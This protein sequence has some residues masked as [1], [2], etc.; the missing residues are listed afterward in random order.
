MTDLEI[1]TI[2]ITLHLPIEG[3]GWPPP[4]WRLGFQHRGKVWAINSYDETGIHLM[5]LMHAS[6]YE[7]RIK[8]VSSMLTHVKPD[9]HLTMR[10]STR[11]QGHPFKDR[12]EV[13]A[14]VMKNAWM[15]I[16][17]I[18]ADNLYMAWPA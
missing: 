3:A 9:G 5:A 18:R 6:F 13:E 12:Y 17:P 7:D 1:E 10:W 2:M 16:S 4:S 15:L 11:E 8:K 14:T